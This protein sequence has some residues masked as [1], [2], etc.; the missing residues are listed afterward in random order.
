MTVHRSYSTP[1]RIALAYIVFSVLALAFF[2]APLW[3]GWRVNVG[4]LRVFA[5]ADMVALPDLFRREG[6]AAVA[7]ALQARKDPTG[8]EVT[9]FAG[10]GKELLAGTLR[11]WPDEILSLIH[12]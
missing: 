6:P 8:M 5:P 7:S 4:T 10:P 2:A 9:A 11:R 3:H 12:I 1:W